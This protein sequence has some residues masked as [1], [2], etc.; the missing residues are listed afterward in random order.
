MGHRGDLDHHRSDRY[1]PGSEILEIEGRGAEARLR[2]Q[3][4]DPIRPGRPVR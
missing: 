3:R 4:V 2:V 1:P